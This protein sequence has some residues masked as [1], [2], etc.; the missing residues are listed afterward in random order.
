M[1]R[2]TVKTSKKP[3]IVKEKHTSIKNYLF[4]L[5]VYQYTA[6][7]CELE[8]RNRHFANERQ[9]IKNCFSPTK[10]ARKFV[11]AQRVLAP[12]NKILNCIVNA[13]MDYFDT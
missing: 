1:R 7:L 5:I 10:P 9:N 4:E 13:I 2:K 12:T 11:G 3:T 6:L 8:P